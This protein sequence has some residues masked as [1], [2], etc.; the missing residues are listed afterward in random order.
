MTSRFCTTCWPARRTSGASI[1]YQFSAALS[2]FIPLIAT[3]TAAAWG[4]GGVSIVYIGCGLIGL[5]AALAT[6]ETWSGREIAEVDELI[7]S[8]K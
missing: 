3:A 4:W 5:I 2:G 6:K 8:G 1:G 7:A